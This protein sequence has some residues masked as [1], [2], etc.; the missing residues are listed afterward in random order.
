M[1]VQNPTNRQAACAH[2]I[3]VGLAANTAHAVTQGPQLVLG[4]SSLTS[5]LSWIAQ[6]GAA[7]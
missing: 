2:C 5:G 4:R 7:D 6:P 1:A 3:D